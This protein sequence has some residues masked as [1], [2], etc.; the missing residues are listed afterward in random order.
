MNHG[1]Y[2]KKSFVQSYG[3]VGVLLLVMGVVFLSVGVAM[4]IIPFEYSDIS[5]YRFGEQVPSGAESLRL[6]RRIFLLAFEGTGVVLSAVGLGIVLCSNSTKRK[7]RSLIDGGSCVDAQ[8]IEYTPT[9][10]TIN[11]R[12]M[13]RLRCKYTHRDGNTYIFKS[14]MLRMNPEP[15]LKDGM[16]KVYF[17]PYDLRQYYV[18]VNGSVGAG[19]NIV[20]L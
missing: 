4:Q 17:D 9:S 1:V 11:N 6:F 3:F 18:D 13:M 16:V 7:N 14:G 15:F 12:R 5:V 8:I 2:K 19:E 10:V 20:E